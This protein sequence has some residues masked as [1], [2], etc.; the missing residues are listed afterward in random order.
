LTPKPG[1]REQ[2]RVKADLSRSLAPVAS[3]QRSLRPTLEDRTAFDLANTAKSIGEWRG[4]YLRWPK[5][6]D[7]VPPHPLPFDRDATAEERDAAIE[8]VVALI[9]EV[10]KVTTLILRPACEPAPSLPLVAASD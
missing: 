1:I 8:S 6:Q 5:G 2:Y 9:V 3:T 7:G 10:E 4:A